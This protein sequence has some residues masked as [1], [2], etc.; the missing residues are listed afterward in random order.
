MSKDTNPKH[1]KLGVFY[2]NPDNPSEFVDKRKGIGVTINFAS[3]YGRRMFL[4][5]L[6]PGIIMII[7]CICIWMF[8]QCF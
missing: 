8:K 2:Y 5:I 4:L 6:T 3:K 7:A 1:W